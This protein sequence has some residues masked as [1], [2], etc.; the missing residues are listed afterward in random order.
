MD[1]WI[2]PRFPAGFRNG[3]AWTPGG[4]VPFWVPPGVTQDF[5]HALA[6]SSPSL[7]PFHRPLVHAT[8]IT[9]SREQVLNTL[10]HSYTRPSRATHPRMPDG[11]CA[12]TQPPSCCP[13]TCPA[14]PLFLPPSPCGPSHLSTELD[15]THQKL[16]SR[17][18]PRPTDQQALTS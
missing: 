1:G 14:T 17:V 6:H 15:D 5:L 18:S 13:S 2:Q 4:Q 8:R 3:D 7:L 9:H 12:F 10:T 11:V 16:Q